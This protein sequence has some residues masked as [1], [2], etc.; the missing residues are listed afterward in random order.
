MK[1]NMFGK[2]LGLAVVLAG[3]NWTAASVQAQG[4]GGLKVQFIY[5]G[6]APAAPALSIT[7]DPEFCGKFGLKDESLVVNPENKGLANVA[8]YLY[9][10]RTDRVKPA[11]HPDLEKLAGQVVKVDNKECRFLPHV[12]VIWTKQMVELGNPD[13][14]GHNMNVATLNPANPPLNQLIPAGRSVMHQFAAEETLPIPVACNI[15]PWMK[16]HLVIRDTP[17]AAVSDK[18]GNLMIDK[19]PEGK[20]KIRFWQEAAGY[21]QEPTIGGKKQ[22]WRRGEVEVEIKAGQVT[23]LGVAKISPSAF[24]K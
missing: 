9:V 14:V 7:K 19:M 8:G 22:S 15:H 12:S 18:D 11:I 2:L 1:R 16:G 10:S 20:W 23:D 24:Q 17:Y 3:L 5:D 6:P 4:W 21:L 13:Q